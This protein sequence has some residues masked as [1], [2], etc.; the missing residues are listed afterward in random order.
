[1]GVGLGLSRTK[2]KSSYYNAALLAITCCVYS[3]PLV[4]SHSR[5]YKYIQYIDL[6]SLF[7]CSPA[8]SVLLHWLSVLTISGVG[9]CGRSNLIAIFINVFY[10]HYSD[11]IKS[12]GMLNSL[13]DVHWF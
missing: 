3:P 10:A 6:Q 11:R 1:M 9:G 7:N 13:A 5:P 8:V 12:K 4:N 2:L